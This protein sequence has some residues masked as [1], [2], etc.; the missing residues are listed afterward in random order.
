MRGPQMVVAMRIM[1]CRSLA[2]VVPVRVSPA[3]RTGY[4]EPWRRRPVGVSVEAFGVQS[5]LEQ[6]GEN[7]S[8]HV[9]LDVVAHAGSIRV[10]CGPASPGSS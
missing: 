7:L 4:S 9:R 2:M 6:G 1:R 10:I 3:S 8:Q 5:A